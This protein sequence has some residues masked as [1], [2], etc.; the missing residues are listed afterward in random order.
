MQRPSLL[1]IAACRHLPEPTPSLPRCAVLQG[2]RQLEAEQCYKY[3]SKVSV[4]TKPSSFHAWCERGLFLLPLPAPQP[5]LLL[6]C[7]SKLAAAKGSAWRGPF[8]FLSGVL[9]WIS[10]L[11]GCLTPCPRSSAWTTRLYCKSFTPPSSASASATR[12]S[13]R[14]AV[15]RGADAMLLQPLL[16]TAD[17]RSSLRPAPR[18]A[19]TAG[20]RSRV[21]ALR[22]AGE[23]QRP[24]S[25]REAPRGGRHV[26]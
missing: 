7:R 9:G 11:V 1:L 13:E 8:P 21:G 20:S 2:G 4:G 25:A 10:A 19:F 26:T 22:A 23:L 18:R 15:T 12:P 17:S 5:W 6:S 14:G 16:L 3:A 24:L